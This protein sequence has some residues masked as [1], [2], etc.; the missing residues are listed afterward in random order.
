MLPS[1]STEDPS[2]LKG[3]RSALLASGAER[4]HDELVSAD[5]GDGVGLAYD[6]LEAAGERLQHDVAGAVPSDVV[7]VLETVE[8]DGDEGEA[9][10]GASRPPEG[11]L[12]SVLQEH[13]VREAGKRIA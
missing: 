3:F 8:I 7:H 4:E 2:T 10:A 13:A 5:A 11:L 9:L 1:I 6:R 12:D